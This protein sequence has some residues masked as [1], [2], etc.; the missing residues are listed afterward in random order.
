M[1]LQE[2]VEK[3]CIFTGIWTPGQ[4]CPG[5]LDPDGHWFVGEDQDGFPIVE[6]HDIPCPPLTAALAMQMLCQLK[7][8]EV[9]L[10]F[11][12]RE[13]TGS[14]RCRLFRDGDWDH[15]V[16]VLAADQTDDSDLVHA[17]VLAVAE[18]ADK[19]AK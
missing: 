5:C 19:A 13:G 18:L 1:T 6:S 16:L 7:C 14:W 12:I 8:P 4:Q 17:I 2:A 15:G 11:D 9:I 3:A 10:S